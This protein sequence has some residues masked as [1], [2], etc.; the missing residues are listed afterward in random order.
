MIRRYGD[1]EITR[2]RERVHIPLKR[3][4]PEQKPANLMAIVTKVMNEHAGS[5]LRCRGCY[6]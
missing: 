3:T 1:I 6:I 5:T 2:L 4:P